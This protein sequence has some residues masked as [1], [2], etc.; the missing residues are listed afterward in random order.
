MAHEKEAVF[1]GVSIVL[2]IV[3]AILIFTGA[4]GGDDMSGGA[5]ASVDWNTI[6]ANASQAYNLPQGW[7]ATVLHNESGATIGADGSI[8]L[9]PSA[10]AP[11]GTY[12]LGDT[13]S[14]L[15][16]SYSPFQLLNQ[17]ALAAWN[18]AFPDQ[19]VDGATL[20]QP[21]NEQLAANISAWYLS[22]AAAL[23]G[24]AQ[25]LASALAYYNGG[26]GGASSNAA[27]TYSANGV[28]WFEAH[29]G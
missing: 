21:G 7:L 3:G 29:F 4:L 26:P 16:P 13:G 25:D 22:T 20:S 18:Q 15:G 14:S 8:T 10:Y 24:D 1:L 12:A 17:G 28:S 9:S 19:A 27:Q 23:S 5:V 11:N 6:L 2:L